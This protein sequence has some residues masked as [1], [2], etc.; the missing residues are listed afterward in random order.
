MGSSRA[1][2]LVRLG[3]VVSA[4]CKQQN[5]KLSC[6]MCDHGDTARQVTPGVTYDTAELVPGERDDRS[7][8]TLHAEFLPEELLPTVPASALAKAWRVGFHQASLVR[9]LASCEIEAMSPDQ[10]RRA[11]GLAGPLGRDD[12]VEVTVGEGALRTA[13]VVMN[14]PHAYAEP[15]QE[16]SETESYPVG[17]GTEAPKR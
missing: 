17:V 11:G 2:D 9:M 5:T 14:L 12:I 3:F 4:G 15:S 16:R 1:I 7:I 8:W 6:L 10:A 13:L